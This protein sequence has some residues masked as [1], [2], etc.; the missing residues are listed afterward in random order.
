MK[1]KGAAQGADAG[2]SDGGIKVKGA[3]KKA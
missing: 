1:A 2:A 3:A